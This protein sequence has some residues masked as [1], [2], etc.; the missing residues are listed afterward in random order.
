MPKFKVGDYVIVNKDR[1][2]IP[3]CLE[4]HAVVTEVLVKNSYMLLTLNE[5]IREGDRK[6]GV[7]RDFKCLGKYMVL[8]EVYR[9]CEDIDISTLL[10]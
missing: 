10:S 8:D 6:Y 5:D 9:D 1:H 4:Y 7:A 3:D 2:L